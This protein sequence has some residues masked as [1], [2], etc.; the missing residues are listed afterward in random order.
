MASNT[1]FQPE[2]IS[3]TASLAPDQ[4]FFGKRQW[5]VAVQGA[6]VPTELSVAFDIDKSRRGRPN[7]CKLRIWNLS[8]SSRD[9]LSSISLAAK[10]NSKGTGKG[11]FKQVGVQAGDIR[12]TVEAGYES[13]GTSLIFRGDLRSA[14]SER[15]G[16]GD[17][18]TTIWGEDGGHSTL[19]ARVKASFDSGT[20]Y[21]TVARYCAARMGVGAGNL[22][23]V[24]APGGIPGLV[25]D[26][27]TFVFDEGTVL[28]G[29]AA[30]ELRG[31]LRSFGVTYSIQDGEIQCRAPGG[32]IPVTRVIL[33]PTT[34]LVG[35]PEKD[36]NGFVKAT[37]LIQPGLFVD[38]RVTFITED[39]RQDAVIRSV[40]Y[41]G[42]SAGKSWYAKIETKPQQ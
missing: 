34:G 3:G 37:C 42:E 21:E 36:I 6:N 38:G 26:S 18:I 28:N 30:D 22:A 19:T 27:Y 16:A 20:T 5:Q 31:L 11:S 7:S 15:S 4:K 24:F 14:T 10:Q 1:I 39:F 32:Y 8:K 25:T 17:I 29:W 41:E 33:S 2:V 9:Y 12:V 13:V 23:A 40:K 35:S